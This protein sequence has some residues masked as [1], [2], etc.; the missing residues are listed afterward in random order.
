MGN[1]SSESYPR[2]AGDWFQSMLVAYPDIGKSLIIMTNADLG[3]HQI[4]GLIGDVYRATF[5]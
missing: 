5:N 2:S 3:V 1:S 4:D